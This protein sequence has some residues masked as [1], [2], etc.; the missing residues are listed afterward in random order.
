MEFCCIRNLNLYSFY[1]TDPLEKGKTREKDIARLG[2][3]NEGE[4]GGK[5]EKPILVEI[6][7]DD[8]ILQDFRKIT[9]L[10]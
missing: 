3:L 7:Y 1:H 4:H 10:N 6:V 8:I 9:G 5:K 2:Q